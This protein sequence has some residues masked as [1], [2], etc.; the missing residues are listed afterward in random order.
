MAVFC[1]ERERNTVF[2][3][4]L[5]IT[6]S[7]VPRHAEIHTFFGKKICRDLGIPDIEKR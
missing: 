6:L 5:L 3:L 2:F 1:S 4:I 7:T